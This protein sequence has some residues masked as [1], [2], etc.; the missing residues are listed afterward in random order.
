MFGATKNKFRD[1]SFEQ[2]D[3]SEA[4]SHDAEK[5]KYGV[6]GIPCVVFLDK[7]GNVL[8]SGVPS[9]SEEGFAEQINQYH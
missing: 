5:Q 4:G 1:I 7:S 2:L 9:Q 3:I 8:F 6:R